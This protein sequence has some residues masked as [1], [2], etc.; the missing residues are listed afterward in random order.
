MKGSRILTRLR[1]GFVACLVLVTAGV[2][3]SVASA[4]TPGGG[5]PPGSA[6][7]PRSDVG[8]PAFDPQQTNL[9]YLAW[10]G[11]EVRLVKCD[12]LIPVPDNNGVTITQAGFFSGS[13]Y[14]VFIEDWSGTQLNSYEGPKPVADTF[15]VFQAPDGTPHAGEG[16]IAADFI[17]N[18]PGLAIIKLSV[19]GGNGVQILM[20][21]FLV[22][23]MSV[24]SASMTNAG[25]PPAELP[26]FLPGNSANV[27]VTGAIPM[28][29]EFQNDWGLPDP[30]VLPRD[31]ALWAQKMA[32]TDQ[33]LAATGNSASQYWDIHDSSGPTLASGSGTLAGDGGNPDVHVSQTACPGSTPSSTIDQVDNCTGLNG[34]SIAFSRVFGDVGGNGTGPFD[35]S[36]PNTL[37]SDGNL[38]AFD[39]PMPALKIVFNSAGGMG[40]FDN[41]PLA[42]KRCVYARSIAGTFCANPN[43]HGSP[44]PNDIN[45]AHNL[46]AP[47]YGRYIPATSRDSWYSLI[48]GTGIAS[49]SDGPFYSNNNA[50]NDPLTGQPNN[51]IGYGWY[52]FYPYWDIASVLVQGAGQASPCLLTGRQYRP[53]NGFPTSIVA[54]TDEHGE[55]RAQWQ[56]GIGNDN[57]GLAPAAGGVGFVDDNNGCD[58]QGVSLGAQTISAAARYPFQTVSQDIRV[59][60]TITKTISNLFKKSVSCRRKNNVSSAIAYICTASAQDIAGNG[61]V[62]NGEDVCFSREPDNI[63]YAVGGFSPH[64][65]GFCEELAGG[66]AT[67]P[68]TV[69]VET[70]ATLVGS[71]VDISAYF[72]EEH[73]FRDACIV[74]G[75]QSSTDGPC[76]GGVSTTST[77]GTSTTGTSTTGTSTTGTTSSGG[78]AVQLSQVAPRGSTVTV[79]SLGTS[80]ASVQLVL[81]KNGRVLMVKIHSLK[82]TAKIKISLI[83]AKGKV[84][85][86]VIRTVR[87]NKL[88]QVSNL[89]LAKSVKTVRVHVLS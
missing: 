19:S 71:S 34:Y 39:A 42:D 79:T 3:I 58:L 55:A 65:N 52:G 54:F 2:V 41:S 78:A 23:W 88:V 66:T 12:P 62:F 31:W 68:A 45:A 18:K 27:Q 51:F 89:R 83:N 22:G 14:S 44:A 56:P 17:S 72:Q 9:P 32:T 85:T 69:S 50:P 60:G 74:V 30:L 24:N 40:G 63:W 61:D 59:T 38:N 75:Q 5:L 8:K 73:L 29:T 70:P 86:V 48:G 87:T 28:N 21:E 37:L 82:K 33:D 36:Y 47:Y 49:G 80:V 76:G 67:S 53:M 64:P 25:S 84:I 57:F 1:L 6:Q 7:G 81:T 13:N 46:Y 26:G 11:E 10:R 15:S 35:Q 77:T 16:C 43:G 20:H 4:Q